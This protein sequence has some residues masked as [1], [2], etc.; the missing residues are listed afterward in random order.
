MQMIG[1]LVSERLGTHSSGRGVT[2]EYIGMPRCREP[3]PLL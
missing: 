2:I 1:G 3:G